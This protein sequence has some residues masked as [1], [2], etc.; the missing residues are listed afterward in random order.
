MH[1]GL[2]EVKSRRM[3]TGSQEGPEG[4]DGLQAHGEEDF[5]AGGQTADG[6]AHT[7]LS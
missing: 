1:V 5:Q 3:V 7:V 6:R 4:E 2:A